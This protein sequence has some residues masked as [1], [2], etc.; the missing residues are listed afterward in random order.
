M[1]HHDEFHLILNEV[2]AH[3]LSYKKLKGNLNRNRENGLTFNNFFIKNKYFFSLNFLS[4]AVT[5]GTYTHAMF[6]NPEV[7]SRVRRILFSE[8]EVVRV[9]H[10]V[11]GK[12]C[13]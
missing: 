5:P 12:I 2:N 8:V 1:V 6:Y 11:N 10:S 3:L 4:P 13:D 9:I 7:I